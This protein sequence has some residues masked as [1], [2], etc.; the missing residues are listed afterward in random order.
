MIGIPEIMD[1]LTEIFN[2]VK[3]VGLLS[4]HIFGKKFPFEI[5]TQVDLLNVNE[6]KE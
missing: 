3:S 5:F 1:L 6:V 2:A 4:F